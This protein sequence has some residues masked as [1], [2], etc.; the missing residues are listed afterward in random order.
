MDTATAD[1]TSPAP[2]RPKKILLPAIY[3]SPRIIGNFPRTLCVPCVDP[4]VRA[5]DVTIQPITRCGSLA[6]QVFLWR[7]SGSH[8]PG[9]SGARKCSKSLLPHRQARGGA[10]SR[11][12]AKTPAATR[13]PSAQ[14]GILSTGPGSAFFVPCTARCGNTWMLKR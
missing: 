7:P 3:S 10:A 5:H 1:M 2:N 4:P 12:P 13:A 6:P 11:R 9:S 14:R 8:V